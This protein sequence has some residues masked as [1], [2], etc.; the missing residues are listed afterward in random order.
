MNMRPL[1]GFAIAT[2]LTAAVAHAQPVYLSQWGTNQ[3]PPGAPGG[4]FCSPWGI[5]HDG[6]GH[7]YVADQ[8]NNRIQKFTDAGV[9]VVA[10]GQF[11]SSDGRFNG[12]RGVTVD[13]VSGNVYVSDT[14]N[15]RIQV[16]DNTG[17]YLSQWGVA[18]NQNGE[19]NQPSQLDFAPMS[20]NLYVT[21]TK[22]HRIQVF[23]AAGTF[24]LAFGT[25]GAQ[26][27][28]TT[29]PRFSSP[30]GITVDANDSV[31]VAD[32]D[33]HRVVKLRS[34][35][36]AQRVWPGGAQPPAPSNANGRFNQPTS[37]AVGSNGLIYVTD[38]FNHRC[39][40]FDQFGTTSPTSEWGSL[41]TG[42]GQFNT[43]T[44]IAT[45]AAEN[46][47]V[48]DSSNHRVQKFGD[49]PTPAQR[50]SWGK[51]KALYR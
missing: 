31:Y 48:V 27:A 21:D 26:S 10:W 9:F 50:S 35:G 13:P 1:L 36:V 23:T 29:V 17:A 34:N 40:R 49:N 42:N 5:C 38:S 32:T 11:G 24:V 33:N 37:C 16:F 46:V 15:N 20:G 45:D 2:L 51:I 39:Q 28:V 3:C 30:S 18:G 14:N 41:G 44:G 12:P 19:F 8:N 47:Y 25:Q 4:T 6:A 22:N 7:V 43:P